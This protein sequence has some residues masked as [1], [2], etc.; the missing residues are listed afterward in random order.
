MPPFFTLEI[1]QDFLRET[2][3]NKTLAAMALFAAPVA[4][5]L[6][7]SDVI[8]AM[9]EMTADDVRSRSTVAIQTTEDS[10]SGA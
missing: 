1:Y 5:S 2:F 8:S 10:C 9:C 6:A 4:S 7:S 3:M